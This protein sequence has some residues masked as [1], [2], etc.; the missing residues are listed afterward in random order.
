MKLL[1]PL[2]AL[3]GVTPQAVYPD[4]GALPQ[5]PQPV[6]TATRQLQTWTLWYDDVTLAVLAD[7]GLPV[8]PN[9]HY[10]RWTG[11]SWIDPS[12]GGIYYPSW[13]GAALAAGAVLE[14]SSQ[15]V[16][17]NATLCI[18]WQDGGLDPAQ[19]ASYQCACSTGSACTLTSDGGA[20]PLAITLQPGTFT[21]A[22][23]QPKACV[24][25]FTDVVYPGEGVPHD[26]SWPAGI[27]PH[28]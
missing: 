15:T 19:S 9:S 1:L 27:C 22:G 3:L 11:R 10:Q 14:S 28:P 4:G 2:L 21:G 12:D 8:T 24:A 13:M 25:N 18:S 20:A 17:A 26:S 7:A 5:P 23:C 6:P 16:C